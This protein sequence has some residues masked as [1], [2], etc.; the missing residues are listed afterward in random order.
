MTIMYNKKSDKDKIEV[1]Q[2]NFVMETE[3]VANQWA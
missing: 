2:W 3:D 1:G